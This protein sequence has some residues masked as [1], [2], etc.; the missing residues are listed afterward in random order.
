LTA[1]TDRKNPGWSLEGG[2]GGTNKKKKEKPTT[3]LRK[4]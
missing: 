4:E 2:E 3:S 1:L